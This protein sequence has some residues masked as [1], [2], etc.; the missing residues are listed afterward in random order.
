MAQAPAP[1]KVMESSIPSTVEDLRVQALQ[2]L[3]MRREAVDEL[4]RSLQKYAEKAPRKA[5]C[6]P[7]SA[8]RKC[9]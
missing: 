7:F 6:I 9:S 8:A 3:Y 4:I 1:L 2:R 5:P